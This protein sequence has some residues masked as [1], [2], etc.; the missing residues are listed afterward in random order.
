MGS[1]K[2]LE[3]GTM[4]EGGGNVELSQKGPPS[5]W[6]SRLGRAASRISEHQG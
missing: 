4:S 1:R 2:A 6:K 3:P 5:P